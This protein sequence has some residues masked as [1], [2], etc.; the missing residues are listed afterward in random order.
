MKRSCSG[1]GNFG[2]EL[3]H[4]MDLALQSSEGELDEVR[5]IL[6]GAIDGLIAEFGDEARSR[7]VVAMQFQDLSDQLLV[8]AKRRIQMVRNALGKSAGCRSQNASAVP[9]EGGTIEIF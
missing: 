8:S 3:A 1:L 9:H 5:H 6:R 7:A 2:T 4:G